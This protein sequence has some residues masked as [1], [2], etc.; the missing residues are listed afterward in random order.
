MDS[1]NW[2]AETGGRQASAQVAKGAFEFPVSIFEFLF[3]NSE[4]R[5]SSCEEEERLP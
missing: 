1:R 2:N 5:F 4:F 3:S